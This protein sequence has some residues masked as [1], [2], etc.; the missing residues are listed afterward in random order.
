MT[1]YYTGIVVTPVLAACIA[2]MVAVPSAAQQASAL[3]RAEGRLVDARCGIPVAYSNVILLGT[4]MGSTTDTDGVFSIPN[5]PP[6]TYTLRVSSLV[7]DPVDLAG[8]MIAAGATVHRDIELEMMGRS[9]TVVDARGGA[10]E[11]AVHGSSMVSILVPVGSAVPA[12]DPGFEL[13]REAGFPNA[14]PHYSAGCSVGRPGCPWKATVFRCP[15]CVAARNRYN[16][17]DIWDRA[18]TGPRELQTRGLADAIEFGVP[19]DAETEN[20]SEACREVTI[21][22]TDS[23]TVRMVKGDRFVLAVEYPGEVYAPQGDR[24]AI[25]MQDGVVARISVVES[26]DGVDVYVKFLVTPVD[27]DAVIMR[28]Q[29]KGDHGLSLATAIVRSVKFSA[30]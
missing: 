6:G 19:R 14:D 21:L 29:V 5:V 4:T 20:A 23:V 10:G 26:E 30:S 22:K 1:R 12:A 15:D 27:S 3:G 24:D 13:A 7:H 18:T 16:G 25:V 11:C 28:I 9:D 2:L 17:S 8:I